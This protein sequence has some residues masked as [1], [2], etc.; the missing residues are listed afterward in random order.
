MAAGTISRDLVPGNVFSTRYAAM[1]AY[2][3]RYREDA[4][5]KTGYLYAGA[6]HTPGMAHFGTPTVPDEELLGYVHPAGNCGGIRFTVRRGFLRFTKRPVAF[7]RLQ[8]TMAPGALDQ[9]LDA[10][11]GFTRI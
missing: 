2:L 3:G 5:G 1:Y 9:V 6:L 10:V 4:T 8:K 11:P 7:D